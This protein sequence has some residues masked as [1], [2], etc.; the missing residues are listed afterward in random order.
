M[1]SLRQVNKMGDIMVFYVAHEYGGKVENIIRAKKITHDLQISDLE[2]TY[3]CPLM[4]LSELE[5][6]EVPFEKEMELCL[7]ILQMCD[8]I[9][10]ASKISKGVQAEIDFAQLI[11]MEVSYENDH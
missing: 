9:I 2:N 7:D 8:K 10:V 4:A 6:G 1:P 11:G 5:Y 3:I